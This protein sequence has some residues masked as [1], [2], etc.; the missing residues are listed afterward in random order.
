[1]HG[2]TDDE[3]V[4][5]RNDRLGCSAYWKP[6]FHSCQKVNILMEIFSDGINA[7]KHGED[8][9]HVTVRPVHT[10]K[11]EISMAPGGGWVAKITRADN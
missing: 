9:K 1:M 7:D 3:L 4:P 6:T 5:W 8:Y 10:G 11:M 2:G